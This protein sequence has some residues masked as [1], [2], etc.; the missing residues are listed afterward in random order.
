MDIYS[1]L[2]RSKENF[3][4][5]NKNRVNF[6]VCGPTVYDDAHIGHGRTYVSFDTI[7]RYLEYSG[8]AVF[9][10][11][12]IT[13][14]DDKI[15]NRSKESGIPAHDIARKFEKRY[16][17]DMAKLNV[18]GVN[19][20]ARATDHLDEI[21][22]QIQRL[23]DK[24]FAYES[25]DGVYFEIEKFEEFGKLSNRKVDELESHRELAET[26][27]KSEQDFALW[28]K[29]DGVDEPVFPSPWGDG[30]PGWHIEDTAI[31]EYYFGEQYDV[32]GGG[33]DLIFPHHEAEI[34]QMEAVSG[35]SPMVRY[36]LH[37]GFLNVNGEKMSKSLH[38]FITIR[39][40]LEDWDADTFRFFVLSTHYRSPID[41]SKDSLHQSEK[42]LEKIKKFYSSLD[43]GSDDV[44]SDLEALKVAR[45]EFFA[46]MDDDF[47]TPKAIASLFVLINDCKNVELSDNDKIAIKSFLDD[48]SQILGIDFALEETSAGSDDLFEL[49]T[50]VRS[51]LRAAKQYELSDKIR[52]ELINLGYEISD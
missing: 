49:I 15:I 36:W 29:R 43:V 11:Q 26:T 51:E 46:S 21:I 13:D 3:E 18:T 38:N 39:E 6:F 30:R 52:D 9:Y 25:D 42:S 19:L 16:I 27:K 23:I 8:Y 37:T 48:V 1:T 47:N 4:T 12:N 17:E 32:H 7:K 31:T 50:N 2:T 22:D 5:M 28:K 44:E 35:K 45:D 41:F 20:F 33:L 24:G 10:I 40:L 14:I 34:T